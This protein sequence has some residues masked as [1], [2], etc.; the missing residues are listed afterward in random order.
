M[1]SPEK[2]TGKT[3]MNVVERIEGNDRDK[4]RV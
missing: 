3:N 1:K 4:D 2:S